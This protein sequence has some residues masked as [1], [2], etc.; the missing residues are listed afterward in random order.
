MSTTQKLAAGAKVDLGDLTAAV[1]SALSTVSADAR[2][3]GGGITVGL[4]MTPPQRNIED[5]RSLENQRVGIMTIPQDHGIGKI[6][7]E[8]LFGRLMNEVGARTLPATRRAEHL[9]TVQRFGLVTDAESKT[10]ESLLHKG[11]KARGD[12]AYAKKIVD[13]VK[14]ALAALDFETSPV[15]SSILTTMLVAAGRQYSDTSSERYILDVDWSL[16]GEGA[17]GGAGLGAAIG[18]ASGGVVGGVGEIPGALSGAL[19]G[20]LIGGLVSGGVKIRD[21]D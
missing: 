21:V 15:A 19:Y 14:A 16:V 2:M 4:V 18:A 7:L 8:A 17:V 1:V 20:A 13:E 10:I 11:D 5:Q 12:S 9:A 6:N 3:S